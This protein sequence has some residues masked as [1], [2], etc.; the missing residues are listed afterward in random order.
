MRGE[1]L[2]LAH[3][4]CIPLKG[5][6]HNHSFRVA[7]TGSVVNLNSSVALIYFYCSRLPSDG[8]FKPHPRFEIDEDSDT[9]TLL[10]PKSCPVQIVKVE[11]ICRMIRQIVCLEACKKL[12]QFGALSDHLIPVID[13]GTEDVNE[14]GGDQACTFDEDIYFP[15]ELVS[16]WSSFC[17]IGLYHSY[18]ISMSSV[19][20]ESSF[21]DI[22]LV[23][24]SDL[25]SDFS[26]NSFNLETSSGSITVEI[27]YFGDIHLDH[28]QILRSRRFQVS[29]LSLLIH[30]NYDKFLEALHLC[31]DDASEEVVY[32][33]IPSVNGVVDW[34]F[35]DSVPQLIQINNGCICRCR[36]HHSVVYT[37]HNGQIYCIIGILDE[38][39]I[40]SSFRLRSGEI[41]TY[42]KYFFT[43]YLTKLFFLH[44]VSTGRVVELPAELCIVL[45]SPVSVNSLQTFSFIP[46]VMHRF[47][48]MLLASRLRKIQSG[49]CREI[50][51]INPLKML[52]AIT[53]RKCQEKFS[54]ESFE[55]VGD[56]FLKYVTTRYL[57]KTYQHYHQGLLTARRERMISNSILCRLGRSRQ[58]TG[59]IR[60]EA[61][62]PKEWIIPGENYNSTGDHMPFT[63]ALPN[64]Y[65]TGK[66]FIKTKVIAD[67]VEALIG[68][69]LISAGEVQALSFLKWLGLDIN[70]CKQTS[71]ERPVLSKPELYVN[72]KDLQLLFNYTFHDPSL[73]VEALTH[74]SYLVSAIPRCYQRLEYL[75]DAVLDYLIT[76]QL[77][78]DY[79]GA[80][81]GLL[82]DLRSASVNND[83]F[84]HAA[85]KTG[86]G[87]HILHASSELHRHMTFYLNNIT[88]SFSGSS[89]GW[90]AGVALPKVLADV[91]E[92]IAGAIYEDSGRKKEIVWASIRPLLEPLVNPRTMEIHPVRELEE[93]CSRNSYKKTFS[94]SFTGGLVY[95]TVEV[96]A[97]PCVHRATA[98]GL[99]KKVAKK[100]A[101]K[102]VLVILK[103]CIHSF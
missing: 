21:C 66:R 69:Y 96:E 32:L 86:L 97:D 67:S 50:T 24:K 11:G 64:I 68:T 18:K 43:R 87:K 25:G 90:D 51:T 71:I 49:A 48:S 88:S 52:E 19:Y 78:N 6:D 75:G 12:H 13:D 40:D 70:D 46:S 93:L 5:I 77:Y 35:V 59:F 37:P 89:A 30:H 2:N 57:F 101:A 99:N 102:E 34:A 82:T 92:S 15:A 55:T 95:V 73:L 53:T 9:C 79:P 100:L 17:N 83:C 39:G 47:Q 60:T 98:T 28:E 36:L 44:T 10:L 1:A 41:S 56:S 27:S 26:S 103:G 4:P 72:V 45:M 91:I 23:V 61:H 94:A 58:I 16:S 20:F 62:E 81:P 80:T 31:M 22:F 85:A 29:I 84:A 74:G 38:M 54:L 8:Y 42:R 33:L 65:S 63:K 76:M 3:L 7:S 14:R